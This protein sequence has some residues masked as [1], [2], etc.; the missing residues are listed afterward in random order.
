MLGSRPAAR[1]ASARVVSRLA[2]K[3]DL[4]E[5][6][7]NHGVT[8]AN[9]GT[10]DEA[11][12]EFRAAIRTKPDWAEAHDNLGVALRAQGKL[13]EAIGEFS[14]AI[15]IKSDLAEAHYNLGTV[16]EK[17]GKHDE[18]IAEFRKARDTVKRGSKLA[19]LI[20]KALNEVDH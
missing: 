10:R 11:V 12:A 15:R 2:R 4:A 5:A 6:H 20:E 1:L 16:V 8:L 17:Q 19:Q 18:A 14:A 7:Y 9:Q 3:P 13:D